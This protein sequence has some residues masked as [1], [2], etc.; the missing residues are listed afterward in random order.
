MHR[1][2]LFILLLVLMS[3]LAAGQVSNYGPPGIST[4]IPILPIAPIQV[5][6]PSPTIPITSSTNQLAIS[7]GVTTIQT[8]QAVPP[9]IEPSPTER[10]NNAQRILYSSGG[11]AA[12]P[13]GERPSDRG[14]T[15]EA[16]KVDDGTQGRSLG[17]LA[18]DKRPCT[19][20]VAG[21]TFSNEDFERL[22]HTDDGTPATLVESVCTNK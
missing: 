16:F 10:Y 18:R 4:T 3:T 13:A 9:P 15:R 2:I 8:V 22:A 14:V 12:S 5:T 11:E 6:P 21:R 1:R 19:P 17:E 20:K 7:S